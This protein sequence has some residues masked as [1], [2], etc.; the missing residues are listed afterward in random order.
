MTSAFMQR[1]TIGLADATETAPTASSTSARAFTLNAVVNRIKSRVDKQ[2]RADDL[3][4]IHALFAPKAKNSD[5][6]IGPV[7]ILSKEKFLAESN[8]ALV[9]E[10]ESTGG[11]KWAR[12][13]FVADW[14]KYSERYD[15]MVMVEVSGCERD[16]AGK[17]R[18]KRQI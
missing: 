2:N 8:T 17:P 15:H 13:R 9:R 10:E 16:W 14:E 7:R 4:V 18:T 11:G 3:Y 1:P 12:S 5:L 6:K